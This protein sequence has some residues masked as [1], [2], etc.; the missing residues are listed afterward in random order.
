MELKGKAHKARAFK[1]L[2]MKK[3]ANSK[4]SKNSL[5][6]REE[7]GVSGIVANKLNLLSDVIRSFYR[8]HHR[9]MPCYNK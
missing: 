8:R 2:G 1:P 4:K 3:V 6:S 7:V 5:Q 9:S